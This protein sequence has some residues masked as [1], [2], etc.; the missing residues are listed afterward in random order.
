MRSLGLTVPKAVGA[1]FVI[2]S[3]QYLLGSTYVCEFLKA[4]LVPLLV[5]LLAIN[6]ASLS[7]ILSKLAD[8][9]EGSGRSDA[10]R[11]TR[12]EM[13]F[14]IKEQVALIFISLLLLMISESAWIQGHERLS[15]IVETSVIACFTYGML[16]L[17]DTAKSVF[18]VLTFRKDNL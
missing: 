18:V 12:H 15:V 6:T 10:F 4:H 16:I 14:S 7:I 17:Y 5:T 11:R 8:I 9:M 3:V 13:L 2:W 1:A